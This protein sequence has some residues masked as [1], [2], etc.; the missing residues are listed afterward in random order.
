MQKLREL[1]NAKNQVYKTSD[2]INED[3]QQQNAYNNA[4]ANGEAIISGS[5]N[6]T[7]DKSKI[8]QAINQINTTKN[9]LHGAT[10]LQNDKNAANQTIAQLGSLNDAQKSGEEALVNGSNTR[11][12]VA[13]QLD[14]AKA[15]NEAMK[16]LE[17]SCGKTTIKQSS[18]YI[19]DSSQ[20][21]NAYNQALQDAESIINQN[22]NPTLDK[23]VVEQK[24]Q[25]L[26][27]A[28]NAL[29]GS[30]L[31]ENAK[32]N[33]VTEINKLTALNDAQRQKRFKMFKHKLQFQTLTNN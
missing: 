1:V 28:Q 17:K 32:N 26:T 23:S 22:S 27:Q 21:Q 8:E 16:N 29:Q 10:K 11:S 20:H 3:T 6:P 12:D 5:Q 7:M 33:A 24:L 15:L 18:D 9:A 31:L 25:G 14:K 13:T 4:I 2:Y 19:N 30:H